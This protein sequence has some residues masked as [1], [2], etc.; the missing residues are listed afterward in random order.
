[1]QNTLLQIYSEWLPD[2]YRIGISTAS[3]AEKEVHVS[4]WSTTLPECIPKPTKEQ[5]ELTALN[6]E[7]TANIPHCLGAVDGK[8]VGM[9]KEKCSG[10]MFCN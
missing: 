9:T 3:K 8:Y 7:R 2:S 4:I 10:S 1:L 6:L 5:C